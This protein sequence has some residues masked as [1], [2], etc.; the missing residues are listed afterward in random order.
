[1]DVSWDF[2]FNVEADSKFV[3]TRYKIANCVR[4]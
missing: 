4:E 3:L 2:F 1:M